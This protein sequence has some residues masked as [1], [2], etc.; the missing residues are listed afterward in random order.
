[1]GR[2]GSAGGPGPIWP[3]LMIPT[4][5]GLAGREY[6]AGPRRGLGDGARRAQESA[7]KLHVPT[8]LEMCYLPKQ[9]ECI[10]V[11]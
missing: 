8:R 10:K 1:M 6:R 7:V 3:G 5:P 9:Q 2:A 11:K 4:W